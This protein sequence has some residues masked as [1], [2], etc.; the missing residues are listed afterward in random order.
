MGIEGAF[1]WP[2]RG[3]W[4]T[5][6]QAPSC[7]SWTGP[8]RGPKATAL[9]LPVYCQYCC[10]NGAIRVIHQS[11]SE[12]SASPQVSALSWL[13]PTWPDLSESAEPVS[14]PFTVAAPALRNRSLRQDPCE[15]RSERGRL[16]PPS[17]NEM[18][19]RQ[20]SPRIHSKSSLSDLRNAT[21]GPTSATTSCMVLRRGSPLRTN[22]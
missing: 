17:T 11:L 19:R 12:P 10:R 4:L 8:C 13:A 9:P 18:D 3:S 6:T 16:K 5:G 2:T 14:V 22:P 7:S 21:I 20:R 1:A 15:L